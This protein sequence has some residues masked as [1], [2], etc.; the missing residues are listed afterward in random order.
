MTI[1]VICSKRYLDYDVVK[2]RNNDDYISLQRALNNEQYQPL[3]VLPENDQTVSTAEEN[4]PKRTRRSLHYPTQKGHKNRKQ[5]K[6]NH[7]NTSRS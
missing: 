6:V 7:K 5:K 2:M 3:L 1:I 4:Q